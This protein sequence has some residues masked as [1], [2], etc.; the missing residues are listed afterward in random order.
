MLGLPDGWILQQDKASCHTTRV[1]KQWLQEKVITLM[2]WSA[3]SPDLNRSKICGWI[4][5]VVG[6]VLTSGAVIFLDARYSNSALLHGFAIPIP[7]FLTGRAR[8]SRSTEE[9]L[10]STKAGR[11]K[12]AIAL[13]KVATKLGY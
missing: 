6:F 10:R 11:K 5:I 12:F 13:L 9:Q 2:E 3:Q 4:A 8:M 1:V 7:P